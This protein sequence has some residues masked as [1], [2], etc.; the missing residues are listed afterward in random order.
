[1]AYTG[2]VYDFYENLITRHQHIM[3]AGMTGSGKSVII[4][5]MIYSIIFRDPG[6]NR[7]I[8]LDPKR[9]ELSAYKN[10]PHVDAFASDVYEIERTLTACLYLIEARFKE[11]EERKEKMYTGP[12]LYIFVDE[13]AD[14]ILCNSGIKKLIQRIAQIGRAANVQLICATQ[15]PKSNVIPTEIKVNFGVIIGLHTRNR[16]DSRNILDRSGCELLPKYGRC[17]MQIADKVEL[18]NLDVPMIPEVKIEEAMQQRL[19]MEVS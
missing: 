10:L 4:N 18:L 2:M 5:G 8:L 17:L 12:K 11:M 6:M 16:Q 7:M 13:M 1:M 3:I 15:C 9:V 19:L 14:L